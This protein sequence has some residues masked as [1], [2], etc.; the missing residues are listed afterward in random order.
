MEPL[1]TKAAD[2]DLNEIESSVFRALDRLAGPVGAPLGL[3]VSGG[4]DSVA[5]LILTHKWA[6]RR[7]RRIK[8]ISVDHGLRPE[9]AGECRFVAALCQRLGVAHQTRALGDLAPGAS[10]AAARAVRHHAFT[11]WANEQGVDRLALGHTLDDALETL[12]MREARGSG[13]ETLATPMAS[14]S[15]LWPE[16][17]DLTL[18]RPLRNARRGALRAYLNQQGVIWVDDPSNESP[19]FERVRARRALQ[20]DPDMAAAAR[21]RFGE[22]VT[23][24]HTVRSRARELLQDIDF[25]AEGAVH[26]NDAV[27]ND[28][29]RADEAVRRCAADALVLAVSGQ[30]GPAKASALYGVVAALCVGPARDH[31][32]QTFGGCLLSRSSA[33]L[34]VSRDPGGVL[35]VA[36][37]ARGAAET[38]L[39]SEGYGVWDGRFEIR[40]SKARCGTVRPLGAFDRSQA[41]WAAIGR[42]SGLSAKTA[43]L[44][45]IVIDANDRPIAA[46]FTAWG[47]PCDHFFL[48]GR[49]IEQRLWSLWSL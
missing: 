32:T 15:P 1:Q 30:V 44:Q 5:L 36:D 7:Q 19:Q 37:S 21:Q 9:A 38:Q 25:T 43:A 33:G 16:G 42:V 31:P 26:V 20:S 47:A 18:I 22:A 8:V 46:P 39:D 24:A 13:A 45:P 10:Q 40:C 14:F 11:Q 17:R 4:G 28:F 27:R 34:S 12:V 23:T 48:G 2:V 35:G 41:V 49:R 29:N 3:A 6:S